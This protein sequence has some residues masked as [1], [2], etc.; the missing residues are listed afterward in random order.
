MN[1]PSVLDLLFSTSDLAAL[2]PEIWLAAAGTF[3]LLFEAFLPR[4]RNSV[5][6][7][8]LGAVGVAAWLVAQPATA[9]AAF[10]GLVRGDLL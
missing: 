2:A 1:E 3:L 8:A 10:G 7:L 6:F 5:P 9:N 4:L